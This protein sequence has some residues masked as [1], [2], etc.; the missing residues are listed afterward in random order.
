[1]FSSLAA[2]SELKL[3][4]G[5]KGGGELGMSLP[6]V[7]YFEVVRDKELYGVP[8]G[9]GRGWLVRKVSWSEK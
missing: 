8:T 4:S 3:W 7:S 6:G 5:G 9:V 1:M 2:S